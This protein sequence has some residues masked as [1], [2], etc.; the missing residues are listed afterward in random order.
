VATKKKKTKREIHVRKKKKEK[1]KRTAMANSAI[2]KA[3]KKIK[4][5]IKSMQF[6][7]HDKKLATS[8][9]MAT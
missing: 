9:C 1:K 4:I 8:Q 2:D 7:Y 3:T 6:L 5:I